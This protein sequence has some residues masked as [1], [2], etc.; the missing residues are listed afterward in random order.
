M[1]GR[2]IKRLRSRAWNYFGLISMDEVKCREG[3]VELK[4]YNTTSSM[5]R[6]LRSKHSVNP[7]SGNVDKVA[8]IST[9]G[10]PAVEH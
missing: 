1:E 7:Q 5:F 10:R 9:P 4:Y 6:Q 8:C 3:R 2:S